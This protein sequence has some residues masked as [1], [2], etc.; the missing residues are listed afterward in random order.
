MQFDMR[1]SGS[2]LTWAPIPHDADDED[3]DGDEED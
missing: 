2:A 3:D 1:G